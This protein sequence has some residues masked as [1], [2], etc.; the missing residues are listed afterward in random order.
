MKNFKNLFFIILSFWLL[1]FPS[2]A[3]PKIKNVIFFIGDGMGQVQ[4]QIAR[5]FLNP[6][7]GKLAMD[8]FPVT[9]ETTNFSANALVTDSAASATALASGFKTKNKYLG[10]DENGE[11]ITSILEFLHSLGKST[12][13]ITTVT[14]THATPA[15]FASHVEDRG[16]ETEIAIQYLENAKVDLLMGGGRQFFL[17][18]NL[19]GKRTD[20]RNLIEE[21][22]DLKYQYISTL[23]EFSLIKKNKILGLFALGPL[24][25]EIDRPVDEPSLADM[26][27]AAL[28]VLSKDSNGFF[29]M[30]EGGRIDWA[31]HDHDVASA[32]SDVLALDKAVKVALDFV[33]IHPE[34]L[35]LVTNDHE[36]GGMSINGNYKGEFLHKIKSSGEKITE[37]LNNKEAKLSDLVKKYLGLN[38]EESKLLEKSF[39]LRDQ[40]LDQ[41]SILMNLSKYNKKDILTI[42]N[43]LKIKIN[44]FTSLFSGV[45][46]T[47]Y[48][49]SGAPSLV[50]AYGPGAEIF[51]GFYDNTDIPKK[52]A[53]LLEI[54]FP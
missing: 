40:I 8:E 34:T 2:L 23:N 16:Q 3:A 11:K 24:N 1:I 9:G 52:I 37:R 17:P 13:L 20:G 18:Q 31:C 10:I 49:H 29:I 7:G 43:N 6:K 12:G 30:I 42:K 38:T 54:K 28:D 22:K 35:I 53:K 25:Y 46:F 14:I 33:K 5:V 48:G 15:A 32:L 41:Y 27:K 45:L 39:V 19:G 21:F 4:K 47:T 26:T 51:S 50:Y 36:T 44:N